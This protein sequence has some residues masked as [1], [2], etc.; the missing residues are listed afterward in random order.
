MTDKA[1]I[2][3][4][5][6]GRAVSAKILLLRRKRG[7]SQGDLS[8]LLKATN[9]PFLPNVISKIERGERRIDIDDLVAI[10]AALGVTS[11][12]LLESPEECSTCRGTPPPGF[13]CLACGTT[14][15]P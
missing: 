11:A 8:K 7:L 5:P 14:V 10:A 9:R 12:Q 15:D 3:I 13:A 2:I 1:L 6:N 4:G